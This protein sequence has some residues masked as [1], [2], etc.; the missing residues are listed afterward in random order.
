MKLSPEESAALS[1]L[2]GWERNYEANRIIRMTERERGEWL[3]NQRIVMGCMEA[4]S[5]A[6]NGE[7]HPRLNQMMPRTEQR[8]RHMET[9]VRPPEP[10]WIT[11]RKQQQNAEAWQRYWQEQG[12][13]QAT[14]PTANTSGRG[15]FGD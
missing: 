15:G 2:N 9:S 6:K 3:R 11:E 5:A 1:H 10:E 13:Q 14:F 8:I 12:Q 7:S 4:L